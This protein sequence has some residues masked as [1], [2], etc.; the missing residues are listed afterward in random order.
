MFRKPNPTLEKTI[1][2]GQPAKQTK[3][4]AK[5]NENKR[6]EFTESSNKFLLTRSSHGDFALMDYG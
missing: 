3:I 1:A 4:Q 2:L 6:R 5:K